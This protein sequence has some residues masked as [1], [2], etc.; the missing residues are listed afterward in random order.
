MIRSSG[1]GA[2]ITSKAMAS[3]GK[4][5]HPALPRLTANRTCRRHARSTRLTQNGNGLRRTFANNLALW[6]P[7][8]PH[9]IIEALAA[10]EVNRV[11]TRYGSP[12]AAHRETR[13]ER[14]SHLHS[15]PRLALRSEQRLGS[16]EV[17]M[18]EGI[19]VVAFE[20]GAAK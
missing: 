9:T 10:G 18:A 3:T 5:G 2:R 13:I 19:I 20:A 12:I 4:P 7:G 6:H 11:V 8:N 17:E 15:G 16:G 14:K 1:L